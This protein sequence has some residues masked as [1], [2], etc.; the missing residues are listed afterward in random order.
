[1]RFLTWT[2]P[3][4]LDSINEGIGDLRRT[5]NV[6]RPHGQLGARLTNRLGRD[7][8]DRFANVDRRAPRQV[9]AI[10]L[11]AHTRRRLHRSE[12]S[13]CELPDNCGFSIASA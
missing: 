11:A 2:V 8:A 4:K 6:E 5:T 13:E 3:L 10:A 12:P 7:H 9:A 1:M